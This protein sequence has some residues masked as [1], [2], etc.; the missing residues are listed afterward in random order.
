MQNYIDT[1]KQ[2]YKLDEH[3]YFKHLDNGSFVR[4][5]FVET[6]IQFL[7]AVV[8]FS[9]P[10]AVL[11]SRLPRPEQRFST[12]YNVMEEHGGGNIRAS[13]ESTFYAFLVSMGVEPAYIEKRS[14]WPCVRNFN[15]TLGGVCLM[16][17]VYTA[18]A[19][20]GIIEDLFSDISARI[21]Q[22]VIKQGWLQ[23]SELLH[24]PTH[25]ELDEEHA[26]EFYHIIR[27]LYGSH[28][29]IDY[30]IEQGLELGAYIFLTMYQELY[31]TRQRRSER[32]VAGPH[33]MADGWYLDPEAVS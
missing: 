14:L 16:D 32:K 21:G 18:V 6:Q 15:T 11:A 7:F 19:A 8:F 31:A 17:D 25:Q 12:L 24:Y 26:E 27:P 33:S 13:H 2:G 22:S 5:D 28:P 9:R 23:R 29:R 20:M 4:D 3:P 10:M 1:L 30:Q